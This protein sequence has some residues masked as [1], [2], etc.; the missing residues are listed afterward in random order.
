MRAVCIRAA[1]YRL[2][3]VQVPVTDL[4]IEPAGGIRADPSLVVDRRP[5]LTE[6]YLCVSL[7]Y[8]S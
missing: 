5:V 3:D 1:D 2:V 6:D 4:E 8:D 7:E